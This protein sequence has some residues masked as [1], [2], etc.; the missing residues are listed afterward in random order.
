MSA[1]RHLGA[2]ILLA[3]CLW[4]CERERRP[5]QE[6]AAASNRAQNAPMTRLFA[7]SPPPPPSPF[8]PYQHNAYSI[9]E[10]KRLFTAFNCVGCHAHGGGGMGPPLMDA[11]WI[12]G[13]Q[14]ENIFNTIV[15]GRPN[16]MPAWKGKIPDQQLWQLV[17]YV[18]SMSGQTPIDVLPGRD[19]HLS[20]GPPEIARPAVPPVQ[21][22]AP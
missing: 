19:D 10:G 21:A 3:A 16:G 14:P 4:S 1:R 8:S 2:V 5:F 18:Q 17:A 9:S 22:G 11:E 12:Y 7:G 20:A 15:E 13:H 6:P